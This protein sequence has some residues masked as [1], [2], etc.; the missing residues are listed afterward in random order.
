LGGYLLSP[1]LV[2]Q[3]LKSTSLENKPD[4]TNIDTANEGDFRDDGSHS[5]VVYEVGTNKP[6]NVVGEDKKFVEYKSEISSI[7]RSVLDEIVKGKKPA[8]RYKLTALTN[9]SQIFQLFEVLQALSDKADDMTIEIKVQAHTKKEF[10]R[11][12]IQNTIEE[13]LDEMDIQAST[14]LE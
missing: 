5:K 4:P 7:K 3:L 13:P 9:K 8:R 1:T 12:W 2:S 6:A 11:T 10:D 14:H